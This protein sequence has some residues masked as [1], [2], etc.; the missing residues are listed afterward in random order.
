M[1][2]RIVRSICILLT[3]LFIFT[4]F[5]FG[6]RK[7]TETFILTIERVKHSVVPILCGRLDEKG[8]FSVQLI[9]GTGFFIDREGHFLTAAHVINDLM[10]VSPLRP[11]ACV[12]AI[13]VPANGWQ[14]D[15]P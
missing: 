5:A 2:L 4:L 1:S 13:Y 7:K 12:S 11:I 10:G 15:A 6:R 3:F 8:N 14:R 9:D